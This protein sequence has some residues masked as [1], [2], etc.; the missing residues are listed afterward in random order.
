M[1]AGGSQ[2]NGV[3]Y[4][5]S[6]VWINSLTMSLNSQAGITSNKV[7]S[8]N[9]M[10]RN[11]KEEVNFSKVIASRESLW[12]A[13]NLSSVQSSL[14]STIVD[15]KSSQNGL[16]SVKDNIGRIQELV[17]N[18]YSG[19]ITGA[20]LDTA[21]E[22]INSLVQEIND[23]VADTK[24]GDQ[25][26]FDGSYNFQMLTGSVASDTYNIDLAS[27][28][29]SATTP[30]LTNEL[31]APNGDEGDGFSIAFVNE[32]YIIARAN[33]N[34]NEQAEGL[35]DENGSVYIFDAQTNAFIREITSPLT[36][37]DNEKF[38][39][40]IDVQGDNLVIGTRGHSNITTTDRDFEGAAYLYDITTGNQLAE[41][42]HSDAWTANERGASTSSHFGNGVKIEGNSVFVS[43]QFDQNQNT[44]A[45]YEFDLDG[46]FQRK[47]D[48]YGGS[49]EVTSDSLIVADQGYQ[50]REG[51]IQIIDR[52]SGNITDTIE[53]PDGQVGQAF[54]WSF[55]KFG[56]KL[57]IGAFGYRM[58]H[59]PDWVD[60]DYTGKAY[61]YNLDTGSFEQEFEPP[62]G[63]IDGLDHFGRTTKLTGDY[64]VIGAD[65]DD[66]MG[67]DS[68]ATYV[69]DVNTGDMVFKAGDMV[70]SQLV[71]TRLF[72]NE[73]HGNGEGKIQEFDFLSGIK[74]STN[75][76]NLSTDTVAAG[77]LGAGS[78]M[79]LSKISI[80]ENVASLGGVKALANLDTVISMNVMNDN[81]TRIDSILNSK[82]NRIQS[83]FDRINDE[84]GALLNN[85]NYIDDTLISEVFNNP[86]ALETQTADPYTAMTVLP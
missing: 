41:F 27:V 22:E 39:Y 29:T 20:N 59:V 58:G 69:F 37:V 74:V 11:A 51:R 80:S 54:G 81:A 5:D 63:A 36:G 10:A 25:R 71:G 42:T 14:G 77:S 61:L 83:E 64:A 18:A 44:G 21:Q 17:D 85:K 13:K 32:D 55:S 4:G 53:S 57:L 84:K 16:N 2:T 28:D 65:G 52:A 50:Q 72:S 19:V 35:N 31:F 48:G 8:S 56:D 60:G 79:S 24:V 23:I 33:G 47:Y 3:A 82:I 12:Q 73:A 67:V 66:D 49:F 86:Y 70:S 76:I 1:F 38:G 6:S 68:G 7:K 34:N 78:L 30:N 26:V 75:S 46:N 40:F 9:F 15:L 45:I 43:A 62:P